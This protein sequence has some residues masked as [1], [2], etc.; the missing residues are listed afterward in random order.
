MEDTNIDRNRQNTEGLTVLNEK[1]ERAIELR[2]GGF[3]YDEISNELEINAP[4]I[5][6][7]FAPSMN[8]NGIHDAYVKYAEEQNEKRRSAADLKMRALLERAVDRVGE[9]MEDADKDSV[10][11]SAAQE[12][13][14]RGL[15][16]TVQVVQYTGAE[17]LERTNKA[18]DKLLGLNDNDEAS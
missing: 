1:Q 10:R 12:I 13:I 15:G 5:R 17:Q 18:L 9:L 3:T 8:V 16:K 14:D 6:T 4:T 7:W 2:Y 11:L